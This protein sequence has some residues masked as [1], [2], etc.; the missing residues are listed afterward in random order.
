MDKRRI[1]VRAIVWRDGKILG[2]KHKD[3][4]GSESEYWAVPGGGLDPL[5]SL[6]D[7][8]RREMMEETGVEASI[9]KLLFIQQFRSRR[10]GFDEELELFFHVEDSP[11][12]DAVDLAS[13]S[14]GAAEIARIEFVDPKTVNIL[15]KILSTL[16]LSTLIAQDASVDV[17]DN[18]SE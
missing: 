10:A 15:P 17:V 7:G 16:D 2:V 14:H 5:E 9:G 3:D 6:H 18:L 12:F 11:E 1:N 13:T 8:V 4:N